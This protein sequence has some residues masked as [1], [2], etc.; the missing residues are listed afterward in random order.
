M[1]TLACPSHSWTLPMSASFESAL[2]AAV[3]RNECTHSPF[4]WALMPVMSSVF[5]HNV[6]V[7]GAAFQVLVQCSRVGSLSDQFPRTGPRTGAGLQRRARIPPRIA[8]RPDTK[9]V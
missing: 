3:A 6:T 5:A 8:R 4:T 1:E 2:V 9:T 7:D